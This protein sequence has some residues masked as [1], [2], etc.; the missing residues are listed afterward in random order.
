M[1][2]GDHGVGV[3]PEGGLVQAG[4]AVAGCEGCKDAGLRVQRR[5]GLRHRVVARGCPVVVRLVKS[6][7]VT[8]VVK[9]APLACGMGAMGLVSTEQKQVRENLSDTYKLSLFT[10]T[11]EEHNYLTKHQQKSFLPTP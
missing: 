6:H 1:A 2:E 4:G 8:A 7:H 10:G 9:R 11:I 3:V 5:A